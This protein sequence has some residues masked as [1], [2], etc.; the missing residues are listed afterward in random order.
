M[1]NFLTRP[2]FLCIQTLLI[3]C[4]VLQTDMKPESAW[5]LLGTTVRMAQSIGLHQVEDHTSLKAK[6]WYVILS[7]H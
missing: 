5:I 3:L 1:A 6:L 7:L 4:H 2:T